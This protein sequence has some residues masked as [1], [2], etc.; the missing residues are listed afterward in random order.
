MT[1]ADTA[2]NQAVYP[3][4][5]S[6]KPGLGQSGLPHG[7]IDLPGQVEGVPIELQRGDGSL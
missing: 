7:G 2:Q 6:Q 3:Q 5:S 1:M 4:P